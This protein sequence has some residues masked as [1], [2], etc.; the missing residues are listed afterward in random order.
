M[1]LIK[2][3]SL[4][5]FGLALLSPNAHAQQTIFD[6]Y[7][8]I[9]IGEKAIGYMIVSYTW[10]DKKK[11]YEHT[12]FL[13]TGEQGGNIQESLKSVAND[14]L[15]PL[16]YSYTGQS[17]GGVKTIDAKFK[18]DIMDLIVTDGKSKQQNLKYKNPPKSFM[19]SFLT[20]MMLKEGFSLGKKFSYKAVAEEDGNNYDGTAWIK[21]KA[22]HLGMSAFRVINKFKGE[23]FISFVSEKGEVLGTNSPEKNLTATLV[24]TPAEAT[25][26][27]QVPHK[28]LSLLFGSVPSGKTNAFHSQAK[29][30]PPA[31][32]KPKDKSS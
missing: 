11:I 6:G 31:G 21:E 17:A 26:D 27:F 14:K 15:E 9:A 1:T 3:F 12:S 30:P 23:E 25:K 18:G 24:A 20:Y 13:K 7:Y 5:F 32:E 4:L 29:T 2:K 16:R 8:R 10:D 22:V 19:A 28:T